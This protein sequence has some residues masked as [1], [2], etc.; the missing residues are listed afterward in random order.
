MAK[1]IP[2]LKII[3]PGGEG[4]QPKSTHKIKR[5]GF[6]LGTLNPLGFNVHRAYRKGL[7]TAVEIYSVHP[8]GS[9]NHAR[10]MADLEERINLLNLQRNPSTHP[11]ELVKNE[12]PM[13]SAVLKFRP[14]NFGDIKFAKRLV[15]KPSLVLLAKNYLFYLKKRF[16]RS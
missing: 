1:K 3:M 14:V 2:N 10:S 11:V 8:A 13:Q 5:F 16:T 4:E 7:Q 9:E 15:K 6:V 12:N